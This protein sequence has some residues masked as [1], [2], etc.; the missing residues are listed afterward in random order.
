MGALKKIISVTTKSPVTIEPTNQFARSDPS[1]QKRMD[2]TYVPVNGGM[3]VG[4]DAT[5]THPVSSDLSHKQAAV[6]G[7]AAN[8]A[9]IRKKNKYTQL[10]VKNNIAFTP[11][12]YEVG[13]RPGDLWMQEIKRLFDMHPDGGHQGFR[14]YWSIVISV[15]LQK[16][17]ANAILV[18]K[19][20]LETKYKKKLS[21]GVIND[22]IE[23]IL[24]YTYVNMGG[25]GASF[26]Q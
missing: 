15:A 11:I 21:G 25:I 19:G 3:V 20:V 24:G 10:C 8:E 2:L 9:E 16:G 5:V 1:S 12:A 13:G 14:Q 18:R 22:D 23:D 17:I 7:R 26:N 6:I 4:Y